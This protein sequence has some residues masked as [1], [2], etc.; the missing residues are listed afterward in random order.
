M[1]LTLKKTELM[2]YVK[3]QL[4]T[5]FPDGYVMEGKDI[6]IAFDLALERLENC[7]SYLTFPAYCDDE[8]QTYFSHLHADQYAQFLYYFSNTLWNTS[9]N[10]PACDKLMYLNRTLHNFFVSYKGKLPDIFF[11]DILLEPFSGM[12]C[13]MIF[14]WYFKM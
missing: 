13:I 12:Q 6:N 10:K 9:Q 7:F 8:G 3:N 5:F 1:E 4:Q 11:W 14:S 2:Q